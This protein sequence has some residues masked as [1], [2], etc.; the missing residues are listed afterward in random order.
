MKRRRALLILTSFLMSCAFCGEAVRS[1]LAQAQGTPASASAKGEQATA[2]PLSEDELEILVAR[3]ALYPDELVALICGAS[4]YPLQ[5]VEA[6]RFLADYRKNSSLQPKESWDD[7]V[8]SL[9]NYPEVVEMMG[10]D[11]EWTQGLADALANQQKDVLVA[12]QQ[13]RDEAVANDVIRTDDK[14]V[15]TQENDNVVI[16]SADPQK[17]YVP[18]YQPQM[19]YEPGSAPVPIGY[20]PNP[21]P[22]YYYPTATFFS[23][24]MTGAAW[25]AVVDWNDWGVWGGHWNGG[26]IDIDCDH[27]FNNRDFNGKVKLNDIDWRNVDRSRLNIDKSQFDRIDRSKI[28][29]D[30]KSAGN[31]S[32]RNKATSIRDNRSANLAARAGSGSRDVRKEALQGLKSGNG[33][34]NLSRPGTDKSALKRSASSKANVARWNGTAWSITTSPN[35]NAD[36][37]L[38]GVSCPS[39]TRCVAVG[40]SYNSVGFGATLI[41]SWNGNSWSVSGSPNRPATFNSLKSVSCWTVGKCAAVGWSDTNAVTSSLAATS[42]GDAWALTTTPNPGQVSNDLLSTSCPGAHGCV[43]AGRLSDGAG[44]RA[45]SLTGATTAD[46]TPPSVTLSRPADGAYYVVGQPVAASYVCADDADGTGIA[47]C[48]GSTAS[49]APIDTSNAGVRSYSAAATDYATN[50]TTTTAS[51]TVVVPVSASLTAP[52]GGGSITTDP[53]AGPTP[54]TPVATTLT[55]VDAGALSIEQRAVSLTPPAGFNVLGVQIAIGA[56]P[57]AANAPITLT[58]DVDSA[59]LPAG[60]TINTMALLKNAALVPDCAGATTLPDGVDVCIT[61]RGDAPSGGGDLRLSARPRPPDNGTSPSGPPGCRPSPSPRPPRPRPTAARR[62]SRCRSRFSRPSALPVTV[63]YATGDGTA[64]APSDYVATSGTL[65]FLP[66]QTAMTVPVSIVGDLIHEATESFTL[67]LSSPTGATGT[68][69]GTETIID[70]D[71]VVPDDRTSP[72]SQRRRARTGVD[73]ARRRRLARYRLRRAGISRIGVAIVTVAH[74]DLHAT[75]HTGN[76][77]DR[78][79]PLE[80]QPVHV[81]GHGPE[82]QRHGSPGR[83]HRVHRRH[84]LRWIPAR[85]SRR[86]GRNGRRRPGHGHLGSSPQRIHDGDLLHSRRH[87]ERRRSSTHLGPGESDQLRPH[88]RDRRAKYR[89]RVE[90]VSLF[91]ASAQSPPTAPVLPT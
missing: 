89:F 6:Q 38:N 87:Q 25:A 46:E 45:L 90:A 21:Y 49:G 78:S 82:R 72:R 47:S 28:K 67:A 37:V 44:E 71:A 9:L 64:L 88:R 16:K 48:T 13:L 26:D 68:P 74:G 63:N 39:T 24:V 65:T 75:V 79:G 69:V 53:G 36:N 18:Q 86:T 52:P 40:D 50:S 35:P 31:N 33:N 8:I 12:I 43:V 3:I 19:L 27:C 70:N 59:M 2:S 23:G 61:G 85:T 76:H 84:L 73:R 42:T 62:R 57:A 15:V 81:H 77:L 54:Q 32:L 58:F 60:T 56:P 22:N 80:R 20:Y 34:R 1:G 11:L 4:L 83:N 29:N 41:E 55:S 30:L 14:I 7:S 91:G 17:I 10:D 51:Y 5:I 66:G